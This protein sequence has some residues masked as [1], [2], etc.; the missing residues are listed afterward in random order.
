MDLQA[1]H[2]LKARYEIEG[3]VGTGAMG[4]V[5]RARDRFDGSTRALKTVDLDLAPA[6]EA[7]E[8]RTLFEREARFLCGL[9]HRGF[10]KVS[11]YFT[12]GLLCCQVMDLIEG[13]T[14]EAR[15]DRLG[16][17]DEVEA[18]D[19]ARQLAE[20]LRFLHEH[21]AGPIVYRDLKPS[22]VMI[23]PD[24]T[25]YIVDF[26]IARVYKRDESR[27]TQF[28]GTPGYAAPE[29]H[30]GRQ[31]SP[32]SDMYA[33]GATMRFV[34]TGEHPV[35][36][37]PLP[38]LT[39]QSPLLSIIVGRCLADVPA[40]RLLAGRVLEAV[41]EA[42]VP[43]ATQLD[44]TLLVAWFHRDFL[45]W[46]RTA[47]HPSGGDLLWLFL[48]V[49]W[50]IVV[51]PGVMRSSHHGRAVACKSNL[52]FIATALEMY[53]SDNSGRFPPN[54]ER[55]TPNYLRSVPTCPA[56]GEQTYVPAY[57]MAARPDI[58][59]VMCAGNAHSYEGYGKNYPQYTS[60]S[61]LLEH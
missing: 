33:F 37:L 10:P 41:S 32:A 40:N 21:P 2:V 9:G 13:E 4:V 50:L 20:H 59:T 6:G 43:V 18:L 16:P 27:D 52:K 57:Q 56:A 34:L 7:D 3:V 29:L 48:A 58:Y 1:G 60:V 15:V 53:A 51:Q 19:L 39:I 25:A 38:P 47:F 42:A 17:R 14:L 30:G 23:G 61:G 49:L 26:G 45:R 44:W 8:L 54:L 12:D 46:P 22:N 36:G 5:Y 11:D 31:S 24:G 55:L 28:L 35:P